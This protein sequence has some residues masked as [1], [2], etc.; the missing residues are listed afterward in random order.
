WGRHNFGLTPALNN[1][2]FL[3]GDGFPPGIVNYPNGLPNTLMFQIRPLP[4]TFSQCPKDKEC[5]NGWT[6]HAAHSVLHVALPDRRGRSVSPSIAQ[7]T[8]NF[9]MLPRDNNPLPGDW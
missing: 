7:A 4:L 6:A 8:W 3:D 2:T 5:C 1:C 9:A